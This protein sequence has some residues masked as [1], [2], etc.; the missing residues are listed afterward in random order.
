MGTLLSGDN[1][2]TMQLAKLAGNS[3]NGF[4]VVER[5]IVEEPSDSCDEHDYDEEQFG[6]TV[7]SC[8]IDHEGGRGREVEDQEDQEDEEGAGDDG[9]AAGGGR[10]TRRRPHPRQR[11][12]SVPSFKFQGLVLRNQ[13]YSLIADCH[14]AGHNSAA[15]VWG[16]A[17]S[18]RKSQSDLR[19]R[20]N[21][22]GVGAG[23]SVGGGAGAGITSD[24]DDGDISNI[25]DFEW[26][27]D[28]G[29]TSEEIFL[30]QFAFVWHFA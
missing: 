10:K 6:P 22:V 29:V 12:A 30:F 9:G 25:N 28:S 8:R 13:I 27:S 19:K 7:D 5:V 17:A 24:N 11:R 3:H 14:T 18:I 26:L 15:G 21:A 4:P 1:L 23:A 16:G 2:L 20:A